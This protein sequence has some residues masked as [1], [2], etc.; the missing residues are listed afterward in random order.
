[1]SRLRITYSRR[2]GRS[3][4]RGSAYLLVLVTT[5]IVGV[6]GLSAIALGRIE[7]R[8]QNQ[9]RDATSARA[10]A[11]AAVEFG[12]LKVRN[13]TTWTNLGTSS[14]N[15]ASNVPLDGSTFSLTRTAWDNTDPINPRLT[16]LA[17]GKRGD[18]VYRCQVVIVRGAWVE[19][20]GWTQIVQ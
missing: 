11:R 15:W 9:E 13:E 19:D 14:A 5:L 10:A 3:P 4:R 6:I 2:P 18:A 17:E 16:L 20:K 12:L 1:M 7:L 8:R